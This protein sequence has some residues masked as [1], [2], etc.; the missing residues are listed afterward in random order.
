MMSGTEN[1]AMVNM[2]LSYD[3]ATLKTYGVFALADA[4]DDPEFYD[5]PWREE[6]IGTTDSPIEA[7]AMAWKAA[8][9][10]QWAD[11]VCLCF[12]RGMPLVAI[13][14][15]T[16]GTMRECHNYLADVAR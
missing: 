16:S 2:K 3:P 12:G 14:R 6:L 5:R 15:D 10:R 13:A 8:C 7:Y 1:H 4:P 9:S 11:E